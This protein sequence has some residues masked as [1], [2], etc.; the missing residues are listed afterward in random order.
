MIVLL[1]PTA[2]LLRDFVS[3]S[4]DEIVRMRRELCGENY[5]RQL[6]IVLS[7]QISLKTHA[8]SA[9]S[10]AAEPAIA[11]LTAMNSALAELGNLNTV[12]VAWIQAWPGFTCL[13]RWRICAPWP[14]NR[15]SGARQGRC[16]SP[17]ARSPGR[18]VWTNRV[19]GQRSSD[20]DPGAHIST[21]RPCASC[22]RRPGAWSGC[23][24]WNGPRPRPRRPRL[25][26]SRAG[27]HRRWP[28]RHLA[29][30]ERDLSAA[31]RGE[32]WVCSRGPSSRRS[33]P[34]KNFCRLGARPWPCQQ[35]AGDAT[36]VGDPALSATVASLRTLAPLRWRRSGAR[37]TT[38][39]VLAT[40][41]AGKGRGAEE[42]RLRTIA[43][44]L[45]AVLAAVGL[46]SVI[47]RSITVP[48]NLAVE[49]ANSL[50]AQ[51]FAIE[52]GETRSTDEVGQLLVSM[53][54]WRRT[55]VPRLRRS[56]M[57]RESSPPPPRRSRSLALSLVRVPKPVHRTDATS[58]SMGRIAEQIQQLSQTATS[59]SASV[60]ET[61]TSFQRMYETLER[62]ACMDRHCCR[63]RR[64][65]PCIWLA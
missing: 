2:L 44:V 14:P 9:S 23:G 26:A 57:H 50:A 41:P 36:G 64:K 46:V 63:L 53:R 13:I 45:V 6:K 55:C 25:C 42:Q 3:K 24:A 29:D 31:A 52:I 51:D 39:L 43:L 33:F 47:V 22:P 40:T 27:R 19:G 61:T 65:P 10:G 34:C 15:G 17:H 18:L 38:R 48:I 60:E 62:T 1:L 32:A 11:S 56:W 49:S 4:S 54:K 37:S 59:L 30:V 16:A 58:A 28:S 12:A 35:I 8:S 5:A 20:L 7:Q 21:M